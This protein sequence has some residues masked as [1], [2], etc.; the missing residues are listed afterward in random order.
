MSSS[1]KILYVSSASLNLWSSDPPS[2]SPKLLI[3]SKELSSLLLSPLS[4]IC[5]RAQNASL[6]PVFRFPSIELPYI[7][8]L[9]R[10]P[11]HIIPWRVEPSIKL[12]RIWGRQSIGEVVDKFGTFLQAVLLTAM[13]CL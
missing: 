8:G 6:I 4:P 3:S 12:Q 2:P 9:Q 10:C 11:S 7:V 13:P 1:K 5:A